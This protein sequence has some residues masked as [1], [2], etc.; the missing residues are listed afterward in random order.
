MQ[1]NFTAFP[2]FAVLCGRIVRSA[3]NPPLFTDVI[4]I[5][6]RHCKISGKMI[7][8][9]RTSLSIHIPTQVLQLAMI[10]QIKTI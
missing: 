2:I 4:A 10:K 6:C 8:N 7:K 1:Y 5:V 3:L 9:N